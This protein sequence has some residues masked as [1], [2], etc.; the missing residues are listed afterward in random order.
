MKKTFK[1]VTG[2]GD[3]DYFRIGKDEVARAYYCFLTDGQMI[4][5]EGVALRGRNIL[6][7]EPNWNEVMGYNRDHKISGEDF[8]DIGSKRQEHSRLIMNK[9]KEIAK[10][11]LEGG[12]QELLKQEL[13]TELILKSGSNFGKQ[14]A[15][16]L[17]KESKRVTD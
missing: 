5:A 1:I 12:S 4:T 3:K 6:R 7:I 15:E 16:N 17:S 10:E 11:V 13:N 2:F 9:A 14:L 8:L